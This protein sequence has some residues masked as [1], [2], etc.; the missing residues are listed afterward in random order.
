MVHC[1]NVIE[2]K[3]TQNSYKY[4]LIN[5]QTQ[6]VKVNRIAFIN[7]KALIKSIVPKRMLSLGKVVEQDAPC[8]EDV[9][10]GGQGKELYFPS[11]VVHDFR[12]HPADGALHLAPAVTAIGF[13]ALAWAEP[14][15]FHCAKWDSFSDE[16]VNGFDVFVDKSHGM[17]MLKPLDDLEQNFS[18][19]WHGSLELLRVFVWSEQVIQ[20]GWA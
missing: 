3:H 2:K 10:N 17:D 16:D 20:R 8:R 6:V 9:T 5:A 12:S 14:A 1:Y 11:Q 15:K 4:S 18:L 7:I 19:R 13:Y